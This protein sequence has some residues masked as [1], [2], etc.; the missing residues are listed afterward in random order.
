MQFWQSTF[1]R[2]NLAKKIIGLLQNAGHF[3]RII[4]YWWGKLDE[5]NIS[6]KTSSKDVIMNK[7][8]AA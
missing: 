2:R 5:G 8:V 3:K 6:Y 4:A 1:D 7:S